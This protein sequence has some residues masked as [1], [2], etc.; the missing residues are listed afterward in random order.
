MFKKKKD[1]QQAKGGNKEKVA[2]ELSDEELG[3]RICTVY[4]DAISEI[5]KLLGPKPD[6]SLVKQPVL[7]LKERAIKELVALGKM[8][9]G[10]NTQQAAKINLTVMNMFSRMAND[11]DFKA[12]QDAITF[13]LAKDRDFA[14]VITSFNIIT[15]YADFD[16]LKKQTPKEAERLGIV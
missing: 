14:D 6:I 12:F 4:T 2:S 15:Q 16:L 8:K 11:V 5:A 13:Y 10:R 3:K 7:D 1:G 9:V